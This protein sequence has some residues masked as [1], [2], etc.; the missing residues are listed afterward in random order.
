M[1]L[2]A[3]ALFASTSP[4]VSF[5]PIARH[6]RWL[7][8]ILAGEKLQQC[9]TAFLSKI[10]VPRNILLAGEGHGRCLAEC[11]R[12]FPEA[13]ITCLDQSRR[14]LQIAERK[15]AGRPVELIHTDVLK[16]EPPIGRFDLVVT[17]FFL[18][19]FA[20]EQLEEVIRLLGIAA[21]E[22]ANWL[23]SDFQIAAS[24]VR[25]FRSQVI[26]RMMYSVFRLVT[27]LPA[28]EL[29]LPDRF[30]VR[31]GFQLSRREEKEWGLLRSDWWRRGAWENS[32][33]GG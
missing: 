28:R 19:C 3:L 18:D 25:R 15:C 8:L 2:V 20:A 27:R 7:E 29:T 4:P 23:I 5:D 11:L 32:A 26:V 12:L 24:G 1:G 16:W 6:Y 21:A 10:S 14:M 30:L 13:S 22:K 17:N 33:G 9:R 31:A